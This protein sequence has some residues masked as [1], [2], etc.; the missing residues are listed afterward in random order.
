[1]SPMG[2]R[3]HALTAATAGF[4]RVVRGGCAGALAMAALVGVSPGA[5]AQALRPP[6]DG[7]E[8][9]ALVIGIDAYQFVPPLQGA[10]AD[11]RDLEATLRRN[12]TKD[13]TALFDAA[14]TRDTVMRSLD[15]LLER[16][17]PGDLVILTIAGHGVQ[18]PEHVKGSQPDGMDNVFVLAGFDPKTAAGTRQRIIGTEFNHVIKEFEGRGVQVLFVADA[19]YGGGMAREIDPR[20]GAMSFRQ[21]PRYSLTIDDLRPISTTAD[22][23]LSGI[24]FRQTA[25]LAAVDRKTKAPEVRIPGVPGF[26]GALSYAVAR[27]MDG[28][29]DENQDGIV[30]QQELFNYVRQVAY[31]LSDER[32][33]VVTTGPSERN[34]QAV[35]AHSRT[36]VLQDAADTITLGRKTPAPSTQAGAGAGRAVVIL[37][38]VEPAD[39]RPQTPPAVRPA[40]PD[41]SPAAA[42]SPAPKSPSAAAASAPLNTVRVA[43]IGNRRDLLANL[44]A[45]AAR[46]DIVATTDNPDLVWDPTSR[47]VLAGADVV[48]RGI[49]LT[50][51]PSVI[52]RLAA[53][54][55]FKRLAAKGPQSVRVLPDDGVHR[56]N[57]RID[58]QVSDVSQRS[59]LMF[60]IAGDGTVQTLYPIGSDP[61]VIVAADYKFKVRVGEPFGADQVVAITS[62]QPL[63]DLEQALKTMNQRR[64]AVEVYR[65]IEALAP[66]DARIGAASIYTA[67]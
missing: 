5:S 8:V 29:A 4:S 18:E 23:F 39:P 21:A 31:Q 65:T 41:S 28:A 30:T 10:V 16:S 56:R 55:G 3:F 14:A 67:P 45:R 49:D 48:A 27:A 2:T 57:E 12:G 22:A 47:D 50:D 20:A 9:R 36:V 37:D 34:A 60:N 63:G 38:A 53:V 25:F 62:S 6:H 54:N 1:M 33:N 19:C 7:G 11:A 59:L 44:Q 24:D 46:Y 17:R 35:Y 43:V 13:V 64:T 26:R 40:A 51:L 15:Q 66:P 52:D 32:Q 42:A 58:V 61:A